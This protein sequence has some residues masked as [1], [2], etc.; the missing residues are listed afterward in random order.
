MLFQIFR[1]MRSWQL[2]PVNY[3]PNN[4][5][6][7]WS[8]CRITSVLNNKLILIHRK[9]KYISC[10]KS[11]MRAERQYCLYNWHFICSILFY[12]IILC[13]IWQNYALLILNNDLPFRLSFQV[14]GEPTKAFLIFPDLQ[15]HRKSEGILKLKYLSLSDEF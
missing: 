7:K 3:K 11:L 8:L 14:I 12:S 5:N 15:C 13:S 2:Y 4:I 1:P 10:K 9:D 6:F